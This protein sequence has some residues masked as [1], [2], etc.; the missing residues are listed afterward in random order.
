MLRPLV[1]VGR[2]PAATAGRTGRPRPRARR[3]RAALERRAALGPRRAVLP[4]LAG[5]RRDGSAGTHL[6]PEVGRRTLAALRRRRAGQPVSSATPSARSID[7]AATPADAARRAL[8]RRGRRPTSTRLRRRPAS[9]PTRSWAGSSGCCGTSRRTRSPLSVDIDGTV[10]IG[11]ASPDLGGGHRQ[12][13]LNVTLKPGKIAF[14]HL[15][16]DT[17]VGLDVDDT[18]LV[19]DIAGGLTVYAVRGTRT[20]GG[21]GHRRH[22]RLRVRAGRHRRRRRP[23]V[24]QGQRAAA[25][26]SARVAST[27][28][29]ST[30]TARPAPG[31]VGGGVQIQLDGLAVAPAAAAAATRSANGIMNDAGAP[32]A[33]PPGRR[34]ARR[35]RSR[36]TPAT[37]RRGHRCAPATRRALVARHPAPA[38]PALPRAGRP[39]HG[40][41]Q[42]QGHPRSRCC[43]TAASRCSA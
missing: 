42:R 34:S 11:L 10:T 36:S 25:R 24:H 41:D 23:A 26:R 35:S 14:T 8:R 17:T 1:H 22:L 43:S 37:G 12:L 2:A 31:G 20:S 16:G 40:R 13:G 7:D 19:P 9:T 32:R 6:D 33:R 5:V 15:R 28:S 21:A 30:C 38:R 39:R 29:R 27:A 18:W 3:R 4:Q